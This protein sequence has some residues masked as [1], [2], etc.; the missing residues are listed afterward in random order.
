MNN[1]FEMCISAFALAEMH[2]EKGGDDMAKKILIMDDDPIIV[3]YLADLFKDNG[4][5][6][7]TAY[8]AE[9]GFNVLTREKPDL[10]TLDLDMPKI[11]GPLFYA[12]YRKTEELKDTPVIVISG[13]HVPHRSIKNAVAAIEKPIDR[14]ELLK[15]VKETIGEGSPVQ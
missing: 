13:L 2:D 5:E 12:R 7:F 8:D 6:T 9:E 15:I 11:T 4:Y 1:L 10:I 14:N 3:D